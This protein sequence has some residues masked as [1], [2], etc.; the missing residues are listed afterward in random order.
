MLIKKQPLHERRG[1]SVRLL[2]QNYS[3]NYSNYSK[4]K[5]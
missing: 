2:Q 5:H 4:N 1:C 3:R